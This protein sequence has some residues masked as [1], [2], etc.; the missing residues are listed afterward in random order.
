MNKPIAG[1]NGRGMMVSNPCAHSQPVA[2]VHDMPTETVVTILAC[3]IQDEHDIS[4]GAVRTTYTS[5]IRQLKYAGHGE[6][7]FYTAHSCGQLSIL[8][9]LNKSGNWH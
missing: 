3:T 9:A 7:S 5:C 1:E 8:P 4:A 6:T 2:H